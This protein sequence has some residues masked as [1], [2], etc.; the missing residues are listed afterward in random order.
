MRTLYESILDSDSEIKDKAAANIY[1][2]KITSF[3]DAHYSGILG[4]EIEKPL[5]DLWK[6]LGLEIPGMKWYF[7]RY[8]G[9]I[10]GQ[11]FELC[12]PVV[13][14]VK[15]GDNIYLIVKSREGID[16]KISSWNLGSWEKK[17]KKETKKMTDGFLRK[18][19]KKI[20]KALNVTNT[21]DS[22]FNTA[23]FELR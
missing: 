8:E 13:M 7:T 14:L 6:E 3:V 10:Y 17:A 15:D 20:S 21:S 5:N 16:Y 9:I 18:Y 22:K 11:D 23:L 2:D 12:I 1:V 4:S 19:S